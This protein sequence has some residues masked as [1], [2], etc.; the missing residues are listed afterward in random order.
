MTKTYYW[1]SNMMDTIHTLKVCHDGKVVA[2]IPNINGK[3]LHETV[4]GLKAEGYIHA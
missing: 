2:T 3:L 4:N 1:T